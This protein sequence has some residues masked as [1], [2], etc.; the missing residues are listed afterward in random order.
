M[1]TK[2]LVQIALMAAII[3]VMSLIKI[4]IG[5]VPI[6]LQTLAVMLAGTLLGSKKGGLATLVYVL[7][8][9]S[10]LSTYTGGFLVSFPIAAFLIGFV[11]ERTNYQVK[12]IFI[13][14]L[15]F[16]IGLV[17]IIGLPWFMYITGYDLGKSISLATLP[18]IPGDLAKVV[19]TTIVGPRLIEILKK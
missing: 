15:L 5:P 14:N 18:F 16:G 12:T 10:S 13:V 4:P 6:T 1:K 2:D 17:Y 9:F 11:L 19:I 7:T 8:Q 3:F